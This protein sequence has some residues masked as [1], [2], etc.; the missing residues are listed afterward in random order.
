MRGSAISA[1][2]WA[3]IALPNFFLCFFMGLFRIRHG[4]HTLLMIQAIKQM[5]NRVPS[6]PYPNMVSPSSIQP[7]LFNG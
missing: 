7:L 3:D 4:P 6:R 2:M 5:T 1:L